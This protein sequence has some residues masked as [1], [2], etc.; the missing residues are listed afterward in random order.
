M[1]AYQDHNHEGNSAKY[2]SGK[3]CRIKGCKEPAGTAWGALWCFRHNV[4]RMD[5]IGSTLESMVE[6]ARFSEAVQKAIAQ[7]RQFLYDAYA[8]QHALIIAAGGKIT[9]LPEHWRAKIIYQ[10][11]RSP[12]GKDGPMTYE[13]GT[14]K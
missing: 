8:T 6:K 3:P 7:D 1:V 10:G 14:E 12:N 13:I 5:Q 2:H 9:V 11:T 4:E